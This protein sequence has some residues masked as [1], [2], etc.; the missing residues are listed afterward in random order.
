[1]PIVVKAPNGLVCEVETPQQAAEVM[2]FAGSQAQSQKVPGPFPP[3]KADDWWKGGSGMP[4]NGSQPHRGDGKDHTDT[5]PAKRRGR[6][7]KAAPKPAKA[8]KQKKPVKVDSEDGKATMAKLF[9]ALVDAPAGLTNDELVD[10]LGIDPRQLP[11]FIRA[12]RKE[13]EAKCGEDCFQREEFSAGG[14]PKSRYTLS[15]KA[16]AEYAK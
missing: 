4:P 12:A 2:G 1:M 10:H 7:A 3:D 9:A 16:M 15:E 14:K 5:P 8:S 13:A 11:P 6:P